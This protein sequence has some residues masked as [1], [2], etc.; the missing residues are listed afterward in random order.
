[1]SKSWRGAR[2][3]F[4][5]TATIALP[6]LAGSWLGWSSLAAAP[7]QQAVTIDNFAFGPATLTVPRGTTVV[8]TNK[9]DDPHTVVNDGDAKLFKSPALDTDESFT[10]TFN[11]AGTFKYF[12]NIHPRMQGTVVVQ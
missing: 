4:T 10:F 8:W 6:L 7:A 2:R 12:C 11:E 5:F 3:I 1:M 9:D